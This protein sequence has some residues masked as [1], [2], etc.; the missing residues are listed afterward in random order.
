MRTGPE[1]DV[2][3]L[4]REELRQVN[5]R[6][7]TTSATTESRVPKFLVRPEPRFA[8]WGSA[9][10][11]FWTPNPVD[12]GGS[13]ARF[14]GS[15]VETRARVPR[16]ALVTSTLLHF[17]VVMFL[18]RVPMWL[19]PSERYF[20]ARESSRAVIYYDLGLVNFLKTLPNIQEPGPGGRPGRGDRPD[21]PPA[22]GSTAFHPK[23]TIVSNPPLPDNSRQTILQSN[24]PPDLRIAQDLKLPTVLVG[25]PQAA[26]KPRLEFHLQA[27]LK[28]RAR[29]ANVE[30]PPNVKV[31]AVPSD[32]P[33]QLAPATNDAPHLPVV[34]MSA[35]LATARAAQP[36][37]PS[38]GGEQV[39]DPGAANGMLVIGVDSS[40]VARLLALPPGNRYGSFSISPAGGQPGS[41]GGVP[42][43]EVGGG[44]GGAGTGGDGS[45]GVGPGHSGGGGG[46]AASGTGPGLTIAGGSDA[47]A[48]GGTGTLAYSPST[49]S[50]IP[51]IT[52]PS[53]RKNTLIISTGS[54]GGGGLGVYGA[55]RGGKIYSTFLPMPGKS[56]VL[57][58][59]FAEKPAPKSA[60]GAAS[61]NVQLAE[62]LV[63]PEPEQRFDFDRVPVPDEKADKLIVL[64]GVIRADGSV[65]ELKLYYGV[66]PEMDQAALAAFSRW[67]FKPA[68][69]ANQPVTVEILVG[70]PARM[71][72]S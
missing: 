41:P 53:V 28:A 4:P 14:S 70:I 38:P 44:T 8:G 18:V 66:Q 20:R 27:P 9:L 24:S 26:P 32:F 67:K 54:I 49:T 47:G 56:W 64:H 71:P 1:R 5:F 13:V 48:G 63:G 23:F 68:L 45:T 58:Y 12:R 3:L 69:R 51:V 35:L 16:R 46:G 10:A 19:H 31:F 33:L 55:L 21:R 11:L 36:G 25:N 22:L 34:P 59:A 52:G 30:P 72:K 65:G 61:V 15:L 6:M 60:P 50:V 42:G 39:G 7:K 62:G 2:A 37:E 43:G 29:E 17:S 57:Q 40:G